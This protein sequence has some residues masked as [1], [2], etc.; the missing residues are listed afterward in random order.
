MKTNSLNL[1]TIEDYFAKAPGINARCQE[2]LRTRFR[3]TE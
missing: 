2:A 3:A 1:G